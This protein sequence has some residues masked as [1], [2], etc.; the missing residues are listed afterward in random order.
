[1]AT[2]EALRVH[3]DD[4][5]P[6][7]PRRLRQGGGERSSPAD[8]ASATSTSSQR[9]PEKE[10]GS[11]EVPSKRLKP[12]R[13]ES[14]LQKDA[15][16]TC[17]NGEGAPELQGG[18]LAPRD[19]DVVV[20]M[21]LD[22]T[23]PWRRPRNPRDRWLRDDRHDRRDHG[24]RDRPARSRRSRTRSHN[25]EAR[26]WRAPRSAA[27]RP[28]TRPL[29]T[30]HT[31]APAHVE[32]VEDDDM[33]EVAVEQ[34]GF[35]AED[36][37]QVWL[38]L[39]ELRPEGEEVNNLGLPRYLLDNIAATIEDYGAEDSA[40]LLAAFSQLTGLF[41]AQVAQIVEAHMRRLRTG[42]RPAAPGDGRAGD[43][44]SLMQGSVFR[45][46]RGE[47]STFA[48]HMQTITDELSSV[49]TEVQA[50]RVQ[51]L[52]GLLTDRYGQGVGRRL[53]LNRA[54]SLE[55]IIGAFASSSTGLVEESAW[56]RRWWNVLLPAIRTEESLVALPR[57]CVQ[58]DS[59]STGPDDTL[60]DTAGVGMDALRPADP[61]DEERQLQDDLL[62]DLE[63]QAAEEYEKLQQDEAR[64]DAERWDNYVEHRTAEDF[65][66]EAST[67]RLTARKWEDVALLDQLAWQRA[68]RLRVLEL[69]DPVSPAA[70]S[71]ELP[72]PAGAVATPVAGQ[73]RDGLFV[74]DPLSFIQSPLGVVIFQW[75]SQGLVPSIVIA[76]DLGQ[77]VL[78]AFRNQRKLLEQG[79]QV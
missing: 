3:G 54:Q 30:S 52:R 15:M 42:R 25:R 16:P 38:S 7:Q 32:Y 76:A 21:A 46:A 18:S 51:V 57:D 58:V 75:W 26:S 37:M 44:S 27:P 31:R 2:D 74:Q 77:D 60:V 4:P 64:D 50:G 49:E 36:A 79:F 62:V 14:L 17:E 73:G 29:C 24:R 70:S 48:L 33:V 12:S 8:G 69:G 43:E 53:M 6:A 28:S 67:V 5:V 66:S 9:A 34:P 68:K 65:G 11:L 47:I 71:T 13:E 19:D 39:M 72:G 1:M 20:L 56:A 23:P 78:N 35:T 63:R 59:A 55:A 40:T 61:G 22:S 41:Q 45:A 10:G